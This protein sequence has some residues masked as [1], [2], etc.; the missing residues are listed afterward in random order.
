MN[1]KIT[2]GV[3]PIIKALNDVESKPVTWL[4]AN[5]IPVGKLTMIAGDPGL[6]KSTL[7]MDI[8]ARVSS[9]QPWPETPGE[10]NEPGGVILLSAED[11]L[12]DTIKPRLQAAGA[13]MSRIV[14][15]EAIQ[16]KCDDEI[17]NKMFSLSTN[18]NQ[19]KK[20]MLAVENCKL[21]IIDPITAYCGATDSHKNAEVRGLLAPLSELASEMGVAVL[22]VS[23]LNKSNN[24]PAIY[25]MM[26]SLAFVASARAAYGVV[27]DK[28]D[29]KR[30]LFLPI[31]SNLA[32]AIG[33]L[34]FSI[35]GVELRNA[36]HEYVAPS[37]VWEP[38]T[39][40]VSIEELMGGSNEDQE[41]RN[42]AIDWLKAEL[43][44]ER[45]HSSEILYRGK[46]HGFGEKVLRKAF[47]A[48][49]G[50]YMKSGFGPGCVVKWS[51][52]T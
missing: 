28:G 29:P 16:V 14:S 18:L 23:H 15:L 13:N 11:D 35:E 37:V 40:E 3:R 8:A 41:E 47:K 34:A 51:L 6:G 21:I 9:G 30:R 50:K 39:I 17:Q 49:G 26:G 24:G 33:G 48:L 42:D 12:G 43:K 4:W 38:G 1:K 27:A 5:R 2:N 36:A 45:V 52:E 22:A 46:Q 31:K 20:T 25:R 7:T 32:P 44:G 19:L 10:I